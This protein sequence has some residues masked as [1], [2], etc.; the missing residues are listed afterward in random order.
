MTDT[1]TGNNLVTLQTNVGLLTYDFNQ[2]I[3][4]PY[5]IGPGS[6]GTA[7]GD[8]LQVSDTLTDN[9]GNIALSITPKSF[10][11]YGGTRVDFSLGIGVSIGGNGYQYSLRKNPTNAKTGPDTAVVGISSSNKNKLFQFVPVVCVHW[12]KTSKSRLQ[13]MLTGGLAPDLSTVANTRVFIGTGLGLPSSNDHG[14]RIVLNA[15]ISFGYA[16]VLKEK[17]RG[18]GDYARFSSVDDTDLTE[19]AIRIG[20][21]FAIT[22]NLGGSGH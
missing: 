2:L 5:E 18:W 12:Y 17:Y 20:G 6:I 3:N 9:K 14:K 8:F 7:S 19:K 13:W 16:D 10:P 22:Y 15:G 11:T 4:T 21:F 1:Y